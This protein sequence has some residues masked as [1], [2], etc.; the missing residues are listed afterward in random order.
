MARIGQTSTI[1]VLL[2]ISVAGGCKDGSDREGIRAPLPGEMHAG[3]RHELPLGDRVVRYDLYDNRAAAIRH[4]RGQLVI[5]CG[6]ADFAKYSEGAY[7]SKWKLSASYEGERAAMVGGR[8]GELYFPIA[9]EGEEPTRRRGGGMS[10]RFRARAT[11]KGQ[12]VTV[13]WNEHKL[14][15]V[16]VAH[17]AWKVYAVEAPA[18]VA[19]VGENK[20]RFYFR[21]TTDVGGTTSA[22][23]FTHISIGGSGQAIADLP[24]SGD[25]VRAG[26]RL[27]ALRTRESTRLSYYVR[28]PSRQPELVLSLAGTG[29]SAEVRLATGVGAT[30][31]VWTGTATPVWQNVTID[32]TPYAGEVV[33]LE[34]VGGG[35]LEWGRPRIIAAPEAVRAVHTMQPA[36]HIILWTVSSFRADRVKADRMPALTRFADTGLQ[37]RGLAAAS[38]S[39]AAAHAALM[40]GRNAVASRIPEGQ[41]TLARRFRNAG[42]TTALISG[43][44]FVHNEAGFA[45]GFDVYANPMRRRRPFGAHILWQRA[46]RF[47]LKHRK[48]RTFSYI[49][50]VEPHLPYTPS[51]ESLAKEWRDAVPEVSP[52]QTSG[53]SEKVS[54]GHLALVPVQQQFVTALYNAELRDAD[55]AFRDAVADVAKLGIADRTAIVVVGD[56]GEELWERGN[57]GRSRTLFQEVLR[58]PFLLTAPGL[59]ELLRNEG[60]S[61]ARDTAL[62]VQ[63]VDVYATVLE[64]AGVAPDPTT[65]GESVL[66]DVLGRGQPGVRPVFSSL[67]S[68]GRALRLGN[69]K[70]ICYRSGKTSVFD[71]GRDPGE[72]DDLV[73]KRPLLT[74]YLRNVFGIGVAYEAAWNVGRWGRANN[75][76]PA[77]GA[78]HGI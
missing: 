14:A 3:P 15:D 51:Q 63:H 11:R 5:S 76:R 46:R 26:A 30:P 58:V 62:N 72:K 35:P 61:T 12:L 25:V 59:R 17:D 68:F 41:S 32:L 42:Y 29:A 33:R 45:Q 36:D 24:A 1:A 13:L 28:L 66:A 6:T 7:R 49:A 56:H 2:C 54:A 74:R 78:D 37:V 31:S 64:L 23:A 20:L 34:L 67:A 43:N 18:G 9:A 27:A 38:P 19:R 57:F 71:L 53:L 60:R 21:H 55:R 70:L 39:P 22:A 77:F 52:A 10:V 8:S 44:G 75:L 50:T 69:F 73:G 40:T 4:V 47:I 16:R 65:Q 48:G